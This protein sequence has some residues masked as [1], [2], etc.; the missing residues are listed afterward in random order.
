[1]NSVKITRILQESKFSFCNDNGQITN[2][3]ISKDFFLDEIKFKKNSHTCHLK[4]T[5]DKLN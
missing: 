5:T 1:M 4:S 3:T 2:E